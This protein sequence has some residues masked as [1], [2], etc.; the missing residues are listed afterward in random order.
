[1][2]IIRS[3]EL[4][5]EAVLAASEVACEVIKREIAKRRIVKRSGLATG[6]KPTP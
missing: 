6:M 3:Y 5:E 2:S 1:V 4:P